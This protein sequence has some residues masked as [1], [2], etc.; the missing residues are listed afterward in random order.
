[1][2]C[3]IGRDAASDFTFTPYLLHYYVVQLLKGAFVKVPR[4]NENAE[5]QWYYGEK[6]RENKREMSILR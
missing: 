6:K 2:L 4:C 3:L 5:V 1:M